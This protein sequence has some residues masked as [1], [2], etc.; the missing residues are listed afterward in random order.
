MPEIK[1]RYE[2]RIW[3][4]SLAPFHTKLDTMGE[5]SEKAS[6]ETYL[7]S[8]ATERCNAKIRADLMDIKVLVAEERGLEQWN[9]TLKAEF[10]LPAATIVGEVFPSLQLDPPTLVKAEYSFDQFLSEVIQPNKKIAIVAVTK[11]R[12]QYRIGICAAEYSRIKIN[13]VPR[14]TVAVESTDA[15]AVLE[16]VGKLGIH[17]PNVS[18]IRE[19]RRILGWGA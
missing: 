2:F 10:P 16:L 1:P 9:P 7:I 3:G 4:E 8:A 14:D 15:D 5:A 11:T 13:D 19:I 18:Y 6:E 12:Y 17:E